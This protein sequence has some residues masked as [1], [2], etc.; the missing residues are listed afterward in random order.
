MRIKACHAFSPE[1]KALVGLMRIISKIVHFFFGKKF[2]QPLKNY[3]EDAR[4]F[5]FPSENLFYF[6]YKYYYFPHETDDNNGASVRHFSQQSFSELAPDGF[7]PTSEITL[8]AAGDLMPYE[9]VKKEY[10]DELWDDIGEDFFDSD[11]VFAN[12]ETPIIPSKP[13]SYV[14]EMMLNDMYFNGSEEMFH[15][16]NGQRRYK[17]FDVLSTANNHSLDKG[18]EGVFENIA[19]LKNKKIAH[20]GTARNRKEQEDFPILERNGIRV[21]FLACTY[22]MNK[23]LNPEGK[24]YLCNHIELNQPNVDLQFIRNQ[25]LSAKNRGADIVVASVHY[26]NAYQAFPSEHVIENTHRLFDECG[27]DIVL[28]GHAHNIQPM[29]NYD[30]HCPFTQE[31]KKGFV[32]YALGDFIA[33][34]IF[35]WGHLPVYLKL[36]IQKG[37]QNQVEKTIL[38]EVEAIP[39][40]VCGEYQ[41]KNQ[42]KLRLFDALNLEHSNILEQLPD[43]NQKE[44]AHL[45]AFYKKNFGAY[46]QKREL[47]MDYSI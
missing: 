14:P 42:K 31:S 46:K 40:Y 37:L 12:L 1:G 15:I 26:G 23:M 39:V 3:H 34:D 21:A 6:M 33:Y 30:F 10:C 8:T 5:K 45:M 16:F 35:T 4:Y 38:A 27:V 22:S 28:G 17:G 24:D 9:W 13:V 11:L 32:I 47:K 20:V 2:C 43:F 41:S 25:S 19:F 18:E 36:K 29:E 44:F 7:Y